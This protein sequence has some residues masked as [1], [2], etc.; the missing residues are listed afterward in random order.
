MQP[1]MKKRKLVNR[2]NLRA[3]KAWVT[4]RRASSSNLVMLT[5]DSKAEVP[6]TLADEP[7]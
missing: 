6:M 1:T 4:T 5:I 7:I 3:T 2:Q